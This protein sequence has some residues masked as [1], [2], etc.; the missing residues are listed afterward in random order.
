MAASRLST[1]RS[2]ALRTGAEVLPMPGGPAVCRVRVTPA[3][4]ELEQR[5]RKEGRRREW[6]LL[7]RLHL[8]FLTWRGLR[9][10]VHYVAGSVVVI[11]LLE[12]LLT[13]LSLKDL[14]LE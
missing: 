11:P 8:H 3:L 14:R 4:L 12:M 10:L 1:G 13:P 2:A 6:A 9:R 7:V 5:V